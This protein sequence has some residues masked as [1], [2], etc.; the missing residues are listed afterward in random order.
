MPLPF[1]TKIYTKSATAWRSTIVEAKQKKAAFNFQNE[2]VFVHFKE[3]NFPIYTVFSH[4]LNNDKK[5]GLIDTKRQEAT[6]HFSGFFGSTFV[7]KLSS[8]NCELNTNKILVY[9]FQNFHLFCIHKEY[10]YKQI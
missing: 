4:H 8:R 3:N 9:H 5:A 7:I 1:A 10:K 6:K 2:I